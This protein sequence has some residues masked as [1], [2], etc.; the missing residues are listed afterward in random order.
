MKTWLAQRGDW[1]DSQYIRPPVLSLASGIVTGGQ[2]VN[3][4]APAGT[5][6]RSL[7]GTDPR[8]L[9]GAISPSAAVGNA[10]TVSSDTKITARVNGSPQWSAQTVGVYVTD[11]VAASAAN[12]AES[13]IHYHPAAPTAAEMAAGFTNADDFEFVEIVNTS[14]QKVSLAGAQFTRGDIG[15]GIAFSFNDG[16]IYSLAPGA[17]AVIAKSLA[18]FTHRYGA[19]PIAGEYNGR[20]DN[21]GDTDAALVSLEHSTDLA[22]WITS[23][24][25][26]EELR[27]A[28][29]SVILQWT[30]PDAARWFL[31]VRVTQR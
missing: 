26:A 9:G 23:T 29:G 3:L 12:L 6:Y 20:L 22:N 17:R 13:E 10:V 11:A 16:S 24:V 4:T 14:A 30:L 19:L 21:D 18:A 28:D 8:L 27:P 15:E 5:I 7:N 31:R 25:C 2:V 1:V